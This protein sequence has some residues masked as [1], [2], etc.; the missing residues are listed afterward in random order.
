MALCGR[1]WVGVLEQFEVMVT[2]HPISPA[3]TI[4]SVLLWE[5]LVPATTVVGGDVV[6]LHRLC[7][8][9]IF[10]GGSGFAAGAVAMLCLQRMMG[11]RAAAS[12]CGSRLATPHMR[13]LSPPHHTSSLSSLYRAPHNGPC[14]CVPSSIIQPHPSVSAHQICKLRRPWY[15]TLFV[16]R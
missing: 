7:I 6:T 16:G 13:P 5:P 15:R 11:A 8:V 1:A 9:F 12:S 4:L 2:L 10:G 14:P 3:R